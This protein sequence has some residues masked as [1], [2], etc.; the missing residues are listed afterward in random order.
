MGASRQ[1]GAA[2]PPGGRPGCVCRACLCQPVSVCVRVSWLTPAQVRSPGAGLGPS[3]EPSRDCR[4][5]AL[6]RVVRGSV[7]AACA[8]FRRGFC[9]FNSVAVA[10]RL[11]QQRLSVSKILIVDWVSGARFLGGAGRAPL[12]CF[13]HSQAQGSVGFTPL[14]LGSGSSAS[15]KLPQRSESKTPT[16]QEPTSWSP[17]GPPVAGCLPAQR[18]APGTSWG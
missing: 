13:G 12:A 3:P 2:E 9:Y 8:D 5:R 4:T 7:C 16:Y 17:A 11:L 18:G 10:A 15:W 1:Q 6:P 14:A